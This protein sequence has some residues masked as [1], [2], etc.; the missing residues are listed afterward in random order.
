MLACERAI[1]GKRGVEWEWESEAAPGRD[2]SGGWIVASLHPRLVVLLRSGVS[3]CLRQQ[4]RD[5]R[6]SSSSVVSREHVLGLFDEVTGVAGRDGHVASRGDGRA[7]RGVDVRSVVAG[8]EVRDGLVGDIGNA[9][10]I[11]V[12][13]QT[14]THGAEQRAESES[15]SD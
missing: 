2:A 8:S 1:K 10:V 11:G 13:L 6:C 5:P 9:V 14:E 7:S 12:L 4:V 15:G 3:R